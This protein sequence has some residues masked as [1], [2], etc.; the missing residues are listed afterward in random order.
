MGSINKLALFSSAW[1]LYEKV[2][3]SHLAKKYKTVPLPDAPTYSSNDVSIVVPTIDTDSNFIEC[4]RLWLKS[5]PR[6]IIVVT[7]PRCEAHVLQLLAPVLNDKITILTVPL[8]NK[9]QQLMAGVK[10]ATGKIIALVDDDA[11]WRGPAVI[12]YL[13]APF[14]NPEVGLVAGLQR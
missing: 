12:P 7:V 9:R 2:L 1:D 8:A 6:E 11:Y 5:K 4:M 3:V 10:A 13:L 14:E